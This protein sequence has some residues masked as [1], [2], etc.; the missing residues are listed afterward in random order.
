MSWLRFS[1][2]ATS[3]HVVTIA[4]QPDT[5]ATVLTE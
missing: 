1:L 4:T 3:R 2:L 5:E